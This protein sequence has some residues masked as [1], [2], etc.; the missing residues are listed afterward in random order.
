MEDDE[1]GERRGMAEPFFLISPLI[2]DDME[3][4]GMDEWM[5]SI[6]STERRTK[7]FHGE[8]CTVGRQP[9]INA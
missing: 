4:K 7:T 5:D 3:G 1:V 6:S 9:E 8:G 2:P